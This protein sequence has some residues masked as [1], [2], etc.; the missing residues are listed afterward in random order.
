[1]SYSMRS[2]KMIIT[3]NYR[4]MVAEIAELHNNK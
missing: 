4:G 1:M 3:P 2:A